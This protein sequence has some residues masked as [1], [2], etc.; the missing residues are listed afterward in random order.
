M[1]YGC[2]RR[3]NTRIE[4]V[5]WDEVYELTSF[6]K[7]LILILDVIIFHFYILILIKRK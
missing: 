4:K 6:C 2:V 5:I 7:R 3:Q 1:L